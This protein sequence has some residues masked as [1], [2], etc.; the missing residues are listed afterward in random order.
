M[1][2]VQRWEKVEIRNDGNKLKRNENGF[3]RIPVYA[4]RIG[5]FEYLDAKGN[6]IREG[7][8]PQE[9]F[10]HESMQTIK[11]IPVTNDH[12]DIGLVD[13][14]NAKQ[15]TVGFTSDRVDVAENK[16]IMTEITITDEMMI[17]EIEAN[18]LQVS[19]GYTVEKEDSKGEIDGETYDVIQKNIRYNHLAIVE[20]GRAGEEVRV[21]LDSIGNQ[22]LKIRRDDRMKKIKINDVEYEADE[23]FV[24]AVKDMMK[25]N[26]DLKEKIEKMAA[27]KK[28]SGK[29]VELQKEL[30]Q[31][32]AKL[33][34]LIEQ[35]N[36]PKLDKVEVNKLVKERLQVERVARSMF[37]QDRISKIDSMDNLEL[38]KEVIQLDNKDI[39]LTE[40]SEAYI[41]ARFDIISEK[42]NNTKESDFKKVT[43]QD[44]E[45]LESSKILDSEQVRLKAWEDSKELYKQP[46][47]IS[48]N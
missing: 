27:S 40:K 36:E 20:V 1:H 24:A 5:V 26:K 17:R 25:E 18:K 43:K 28:D 6:V 8:L 31:T 16:Y 11:G 29:E 46:L 4:T 12:P 38:K 47:S 41:D 23:K 42:I 21:R 10:N 13:T 33:D 45:N 19:M 37:D 48:S 9:V 32:Q 22:C 35:S 14:N 34:A 44:A 15:F 3:V 7:R 30:D 39:D 2:R